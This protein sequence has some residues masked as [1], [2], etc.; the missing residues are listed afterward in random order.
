V[1]DF[2]IKI[3]GLDEVERK[4]KDLSRNG[5]RRALSKGMR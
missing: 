5:A 2:T 1:T 3:E 4:L